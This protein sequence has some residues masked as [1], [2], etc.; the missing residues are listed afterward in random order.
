MFAC[1][2]I[3]KWYLYISDII[4][5]LVY[6]KPHVVHSLKVTSG[7]SLP[8]AYCSLWS[9]LPQHKVMHCCLLNGIHASYSSLLSQ[10]HAS[11]RF[12]PVWLN[13]TSQC[14]QLN[15]CKQNSLHPSPIHLY[16]P[17]LCV[18]GHGSALKDGGKCLLSCSDTARD[19]CRGPHKG[20]SGKTCTRGQA[21]HEPFVGSLFSKFIL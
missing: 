4:L 15:W 10:M 21:H 1:E 5:R 3:W 14:L 17:H 12:S 20:C 16:P 6:V 8:P 7:K 19:S 18:W 2:E 9:P 11:A 13:R